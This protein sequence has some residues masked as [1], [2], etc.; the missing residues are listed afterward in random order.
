[1]NDTHAMETTKSRLLQAVLPHVPFDGWSEAAFAAAI[2]DSETPPALAR[3]LFPRGGIDLALAYHAAGDQQ[4]RQTLATTDMAALRFRDRIA[5]ALRLRLQLADRECVRR[6]AAL[7]A[8][9][10]NAAAGS[11]AIW[12]TADTVWTALGDTSTDFNWYTKRASLS[13]VYAATLLFWLGDDSTDQVAT[14]QFLDRRIENVMS[15]EKAK[16]SFRE[17]PLGK[18]LATGPLKILERIRAPKG[19]NDLPGKL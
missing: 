1:M 6:G 17:N 15:F 8:L 9:P 16:A 7:F 14:W 19:A 3:A 5:T 12:A 11:R 2:T 13:A 10:H 18:A 4:L